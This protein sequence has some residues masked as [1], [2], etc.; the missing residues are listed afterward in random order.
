MKRINLYDWFQCEQSLKLDV[1]FVRL[2]IHLYTSALLAFAAAILDLS[3]IL[4]RGPANVDSGADTGGVTAGLINTR[5]VGLALSFGFRFLFFW[6]F[7]GERPRGEQP[8]SPSED[9]KEHPYSREHSADWKRWGFLGFTLKWS[10]L[11]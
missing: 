11:G 7:V 6:T 4:S 2:A 3:Q 5:E 10:L 1:F 8:L 9:N